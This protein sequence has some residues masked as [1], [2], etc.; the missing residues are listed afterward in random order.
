M[1]ATPSKRHERCRKAADNLITR[2]QDRAICSAL[3]PLLTE[4]PEAEIRARRYLPSSEG[5][6]EKLFL[7]VAGLV[8]EYPCPLPEEPISFGASLRRLA[9]HPDVNAKGVERR[10]ELL[11]QLEQEALTSPLHSLIVQARGAKIPVDFRELLFDLDRWQYPDHKAQLRWAKDFWCVEPEAD[12]E[13]GAESLI[14]P[15]AET[16]AEAK[17]A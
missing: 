14:E 6:W 9:N 17:E 4:L 10:L 2:C 12:S 11:L 3:R 16:A 13:S 1:T 5:I 8:A 7:R 15:P